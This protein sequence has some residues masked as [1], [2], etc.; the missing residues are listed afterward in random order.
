MNAVAYATE[1]RA[2]PRRPSPG[3]VH[4]PVR[5]LLR[6]I[7][8]F[9]TVLG[10]EVAR[11]GRREPWPHVVM[12]ARGCSQLVLH[13]RREPVPRGTAES[14]TLTVTNIEEVRDRVWDAGVP[15]ARGEAAPAQ[16][17]D[18]GTRRSLYVRDPDGHDL[19][20]AAEVTLTPGAV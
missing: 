3:V 9:A 11:D 4:L 12:T 2:A 17:V 19:E 16:I 10:Y 5:S 1:L 6:S 13:A 15:I 20:L 18:H 8:F 7:D 14:T